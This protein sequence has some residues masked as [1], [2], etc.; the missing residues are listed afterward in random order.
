MSTFNSRTEYLGSHGLVHVY[1]P[2]WKP[3]TWAWMHGWPN[4]WK[5]LW[6]ASYMGQCEA[7]HVF[8]HVIHGCLYNQALADIRSIGAGIKC[9]YCRC[10]YISTCPASKFLKKG[11]S[12]KYILVLADFLKTSHIFYSKWPKYPE[13]CKQCN[14]TEK[15]KVVK[16]SNPW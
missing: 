10:Y 2:S 15:K 8:W 4:K 7:W 5:K 6:M 1:M 13:I 3:V 12:G 9:L 14:K 11:L 16:L